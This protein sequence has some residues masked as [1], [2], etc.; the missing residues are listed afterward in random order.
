MAR[1]CRIVRF[2]YGYVRT[3]DPERQKHISFADNVKETQKTWIQ[4]DSRWAALRFALRSGGAPSVNL[5]GTLSAEST[6]ESIV[7]NGMLPTHVSPGRVAECLA[8]PPR[9][10]PSLHQA[11][12]QI[13]L[14]FR[15][16]LLADYSPNFSL[17]A[18]FTPSFLTR[19]LY[20][21]FAKLYQTTLIIQWWKMLN[22]SRKERS[23]RSVG[24][25]L[26]DHTMTNQLCFYFPSSIYLPLL[27]QTET[28]GHLEGHQSKTLYL[29]AS[30]I[31]VFTVNGLKDAELQECPVSD[32]PRPS[33]EASAVSIFCH[34]S[35]S[36]RWN[37]SFPNFRH[38]TNISMRLTSS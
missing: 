19:K 8:I 32:A 6:A 38:A 31:L 21:F 3:N 29:L 17:S 9:Y 20:F 7:S 27:N 14:L 35:R 34:L 25:K 23:H 26:N 10:I 16:P 18:R 11:A 2:W 12:L 15:Q 33:D 28:S 1:Y 22:H 4:T 13:D 36:W 30:N 24:W 5:S 37:F